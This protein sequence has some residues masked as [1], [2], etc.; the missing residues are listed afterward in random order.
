MKGSLTV[1]LG[2]AVGGILLA[3]MAFALVLKWRGRIGDAV[4]AHATS[5]LLLA[6]WVVLRGDWAQW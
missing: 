2:M 5:N 1:R 4:V 3:G 6:A